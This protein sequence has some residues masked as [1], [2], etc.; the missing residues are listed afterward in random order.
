[1]VSNSRRRGRAAANPESSSNNNP[2]DY[3]SDDTLRSEDDG[4]GDGEAAYDAN[5][6]DSESL[7]RSF[8]IWKAKVFKIILP[9]TAVPIMM[10]MMDLIDP[11][12]GTLQYIRKMSNTTLDNFGNFP[13]L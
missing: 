9:A 11:E 8:E 7:F 5:I 13:K 4:E 10:G 12:Q 3:H 1:M 6:T 2:N